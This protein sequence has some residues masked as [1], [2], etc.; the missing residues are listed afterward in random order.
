VDLGSELGDGEAAR[1]GG[2]RE[3]RG[4]RV[5][6]APLAAQGIRAPVLLLAVASTVL[7]GV[8]YLARAVRLRRG[9]PAAS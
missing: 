3:D 1:R 2:Q 6:D 5:P 9:T 4:Q 7:T 8:D